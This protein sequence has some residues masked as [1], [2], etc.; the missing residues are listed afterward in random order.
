MQGFSTKT[1]KRTEILDSFKSTTD[2]A[3]LTETKILASEKSVIENEWDGW[4]HHSHHPG[5]S[6]QA[7]VTILLKRGI[8]ATPTDW[9]KSEIV[10]GRICW[11]LLDIGGRAVLIIGVYA[12]SHGD[13][14]EF[15]EKLFEILNTV[16]HDHVIMAGDWNH[17]LD[18]SLDYAGYTGSIP[19][20]RQREKL[21]QCIANHGLSDI[22]RE[23]R[24]NKIEF[25]WRKSGKHSTQS[26]LDFFLVDEGLRGSCK[27]AGQCGGW[28]SSWSDHRK[29]ELKLDL[30]NIQRGK[31]Y[32]KL[33]NSYLNEKEYV[34]QI[35]Q[36][37]SQAIWE[38]QA[39][40]G[41]GNPEMH[42]LTS[43]QNMTPLERS[44][45]QVRMNP[46][47]LLEWLLYKFRETSQAYARRRR[48]DVLGE[49]SKIEHE[50][51]KLQEIVDGQWK[52]NPYGFLTSE[53]TDE[54]IKANGD[55]ADLYRR[56][57]DL[58]NYINQGTMIRT[59]KN[60]QCESEADPRTFFRSEKYFGEQRYIGILEVATGEE[61]A[62]L[63]EV[64][65]QGEIEDE[66]NDFYS[67]LYAKRETNSSEDDIRDF[68]GETGYGMFKDSVNKKVPKPILESIDG[69]LSATEVLAALK[70]GKHGKAPGQDGFTREFYKVFADE[71]LP[72]IMQYVEFSKERG[73]LSEHQR[74]GVITL[75][76]KGKKDKRQLKNWRP[77]TL[78]NTLYKII[79]GAI[80]TR[81]KKV[82][83]HII[84]EDQKGF[85]DGRY[86]GE[87]TR[88]LYDTICD[89]WHL[90][91]RGIIL[92][93]DFEK[94][95][96]S[97]SFSFIESVLKLAGF[98][99]TLQCWI[100]VLLKDFRGTVN[101]V[102][103]LLSYID[104]ARGARQ[105]DPI[106]SL[107]FVL[108]IEILLIAIRC[109]QNI[110]PYCFDKAPV[111]IF[112]TR[113]ARPEPAISI[114]AEA[115]AD[116][117]SLI[118]PYDEGSIRAATEVLN[119]FSKISGL[120]I[121]QG[122]TQVLKIGGAADMP[123]LAPDLGLK[124]VKELTILGINLMADPA[125]TI[126]NFE[127]KLGEVNSIFNKWQYR[128][129]TVYGRIK[130]VKT[131]ALSK[132]THV[133]QI[134]PQLD[135]KRIKTLQ[136]AVNDFIWKKGYQ[137]KTVVDFETAQ[138]PPWAG[139]LGIPNIGKFW[140]ALQGNWIHRFFRAPD[141][142]PWKRLAMRDLK[143]ALH[144]PD[145]ELSDLTSITPRKI[146]T[147]AGN[148]S[149]PF[150]RKIWNNLQGYTE[151][152]LTSS[153]T[154]ESLIEHVI[155][156]SKLLTT[157]SGSPLDKRHF[158]RPVSLF[159]ETI[160]NVVRY[161][162]DHTICAATDRLDEITSVWPDQI[163]HNQVL[164]LVKVV[165]PFLERMNLKEPIYEALS[166]VKMPTVPH[167]GWSRYS[168]E[169]QK[170]R[171]IRLAVTKA[172]V[173]TSKRQKWED[174]WLEKGIR[175]MTPARWD[176]L[177]ERN[178]HLKCNARIKWEE[179]RISIGRQ[180]LNWLYAKYQPHGNPILSLCSFC[181]TE[182]EDEIHLYTRCY[183]IN[184]YWAESRLWYFTILGCKP[185]LRTSGPKIFGFEAEP[186]N[187]LENIFYRS[188]RYAVFKARH[189]RTPP[190][191]TTLRGLVFD[192][193]ERKYSHNKHLR[194][195]ESEQVAI[196]WYLRQRKERPLEPLF[197][198]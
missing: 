155:W 173:L 61:G 35:K 16:D 78:L 164:S 176:N 112:R 85:V 31:G 178:S 114:K 154:E 66:I 182:E 20:P 184:E 18:T 12:P 3:I 24:P 23:Q 115:F 167:I 125:L 191:L 44:L 133:V 19:R 50:I 42:T 32:W 45:I 89:A 80:A 195:E 141:S 107:L 30:D 73:I 166:G 76:P 129:L 186:W 25:T 118:M 165:V 47:Q 82:L 77:I 96:D 192:E 13:Q 88:M 142:C 127:E 101:H 93:I 92:S 169:I 180:E 64:T 75:L 8:S 9:N 188:V 5:P 177:Y 171:E 119:R 149:N 22:F 172:Q 126:N 36:T 1:E 98:N 94:A 106:S 116:D 54:V 72:F 46:H 6:P 122:K 170:S 103:N 49:Q 130:I 144:M 43:I 132:L 40:K 81:V 181:R 111:N 139:G 113:Q 79:S 123:D 150:W 59:G 4:S 110:L 99:E 71:L 145:L 51:T 11:V 174:K 157:E 39:A 128:N 91:K 143:T 135:E 53:E 56:L 37:L 179:Y 137:K 102:G 100:K 140:D 124:W 105:G 183:M 108:C 68:M 194:Y 34:S 62:E 2:V 10:A 159:M 109:N 185:P 187:S 58:R 134:I 136:K 69:D 70:K 67:K 63:K 121:N 65:L 57:K 52:R 33:N 29:V 152:Y 97:V 156:D 48:A 120:T 104:I 151:S 28:I 161:D 7:G 163:C 15:H 26:R 41:T 87:V 131:L 38:L 17:G 168:H 198:K 162:I 60:W 175:F 117:C 90:K 95:F 83:P 147:H 193:L 138:L 14:P 84:N 27:R 148:I 190:D 55:I 160:G 196:S 86:G 189:S 158:Q 146:G 197:G 74:I 21:L 153:A